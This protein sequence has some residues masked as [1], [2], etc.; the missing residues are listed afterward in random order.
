MLIDLCTRLWRQF[1]TSKFCVRFGW[2][3]PEWEGMAGWGMGEEVDTGCWILDT[4][5]WILD[6]GCWILGAG[7]GIGDA[8]RG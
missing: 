2:Y 5:Y 8:G 6:A 1:F 7:C 3:W 4:G